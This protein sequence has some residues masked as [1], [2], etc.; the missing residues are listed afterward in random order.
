MSPIVSSSS[1]LLSCGFS[2]SLPVPP[3]FLLLP[4]L[5]F[6]FL[7]SFFLFHQSTQIVIYTRAQY[8]SWR[9]LSWT[10]DNIHRSLYMVLLFL[11]YLLS[12]QSPGISTCSCC[13]TLTTYSGK[14]GWGGHVPLNVT[15]SNPTHP[16]MFST[17]GDRKPNLN[18]IN[19]VGFFSLTLTLAL[20]TGVAFVETWLLQNLFMGSWK[21][22]AI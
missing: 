16:M 18:L 14:W 5:V 12:P 2:S 20:T 17:V 9:F 4:H 22:F 6:I 15:F 10:S 21:C 13:L 11:F 1:L 8:I 7:R 3:P 19:V